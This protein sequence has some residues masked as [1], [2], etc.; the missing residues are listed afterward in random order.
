MDGVSVIT[1]AYNSASV[2]E[3][4]VR[5]VGTQSLPPREHVVIDDGSTD[6]TAAIVSALQQEFPNL[7]LLRQPRGGAARA[8]NT[9]IEA[10]SGRYIAFL[11]S[12]DVWDAHKLEAQIE[13]M[14]QNRV[15][16]SYGDYLDI[17]AATGRT[18]GRHQAPDRLHHAELMYGCPIGCLTVAYDQETLGKSYMPEVAR[19]H[20]WALWL[21]L[22][23]NGVAGRRYP[24]CHAFY[25]RGGN[26]LSSA[27]FAKAADI[28]RVYRD[29]EG[30]GPIASAGYLIAHTVSALR[31]RPVHIT[32]DRT[33]EAD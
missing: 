8:R 19:G 5:S 3:R 18:L 26:S 7:R 1:A 12:D 24:G 22:T 31:K 10:A 4:N 9:G 13:F 28:Y 15:P 30:L 14:Q 11:D 32:K 2:I 27:K 17:D 16:F 6:D 20:D 23:R 21:A 25:H 33:R 29:Q